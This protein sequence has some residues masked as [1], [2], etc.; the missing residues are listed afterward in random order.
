MRRRH[1]EIPELARAFGAFL[2][3]TLLAGAACAPPP[4]S[5]EV[6]ATWTG[7]EI[8]ATELDRYLLSLHP[9]QRSPGAGEEPGRWLR[10]HLD[11][12]FQH[13]VLVTDEALEALDQDPAFRAA[14][15][16]RSR[17]ALAR[18]YLE[19]LNETFE[20]TLDEARA[21]Y[22]EHRESSR[23]PERRSFYHL[24][25]AFPAGA[26]PAEKAAVC[27]RAE[28]LRREIAGGAS[29]EEMVRRQ[30]DSSNAASGGL[31]D[32]V[33][34]HQIRGE[35]GE[36]L[37][38]LSIGETSEVVRT[39]AGCQLF[40]LRQI[41]P[42][43]DPAFETVADRI[44]GALVDQRRQDLYRQYLEELASAEGLTLPP[45]FFE[46]E[47][48]SE[49]P[50]DQVVFESGEIRITR[51]DVE[52]TRAANPAASFG[53]TL[54]VLIGD[55]V[56]A[57]A[58]RRDHAEATERGLERI[59]RG[60]AL[61]LLLR[62]SRLAY[63]EQEAGD[64]ELQDYY[65]RHR[66]RYLTDPQVEL[67]LI[68]WP[69]AGGDPV[70]ALRRPRELGAVLG[71]G[72]TL[73]EAWPRFSEDAGIEREAVPLASLRHL[74][75]ARPGLTSVLRSELVE[76]TASEPFPLPAPDGTVRVAIFQVLT[77][78]PPRQASFLEVRPRVLAEFATD[79]EVG[80]GERW[81]A[82]LETRHGYR[83]WEEHLL[84]FSDQL[85]ER[86]APESLSPLPG[87]DAG[88]A[89]DSGE[90]EAGED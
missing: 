62:D 29:F 26:S 86:L 39:P 46:P 47:G 69:L 19:Q 23:T 22:E 9:R 21:F 41:L 24:L 48:P 36:V 51:A 63:A 76:G 82:D 61:P 14:F 78:I 6:L 1:A 53:Q 89:P 44:I 11:Q 49:G 31:V 3:A 64:E 27:A 42:A 79:A 84:D 75:R 35:A 83:V 50:P 90:S 32:P 45:E 67:A 54:T 77:Y 57:R 52:A 72:E 20:I 28:E 30:S 59:R 18:S 40:H 74:A 65:Q 2:A 71:G 8:R 43:L 88:P 70:R 37:F 16:H 10:G 73:D 85:V 68:S 34:R 5:P 81:Q 25:L 80:L 55:A 12:I 7:G 56:F 13:Q 17:S 4:P 33:A 58:F 38:R 66:S 87:E 15:E 60:V